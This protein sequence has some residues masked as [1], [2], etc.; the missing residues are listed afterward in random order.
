MQ[1]GAF[2]FDQDQLLTGFG[3]LFELV[4]EGVGLL[5]KAV[6]L[7]LQVLGLL[8]LVVQSVLQ[9]SG[10]LRAL[11]VGVGILQRQLLVFQLG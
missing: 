9:L 3:G 6:N 11:F 7:M 10:L 4:G 1:L 2:V 5:G 8:G